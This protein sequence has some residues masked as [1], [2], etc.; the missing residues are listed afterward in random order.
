M[1]SEKVKEILKFCSEGKDCY[2]GC[3]YKHDTHCVMK[4]SKQA[5][6]LINKLESENEEQYKRIMELEQD[7]VHADENVF[8]REC[9]V[10]LRENEIKEQALK[11][12]AERLKEKIKNF[13][14]T[15]YEN[16]YYEVS[17]SFA[18]SEID[19]ILKEFLK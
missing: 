14:G 11:Q 16:A 18:C 19:E 13:C 6:T 9:N 5:L 12:F 2:D 4:I 17:K 10:T 15:E 3:P 1:E 8:Y 7:L